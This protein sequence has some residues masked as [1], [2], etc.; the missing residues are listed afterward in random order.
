[1]LA[2]S[3]HVLAYVSLQALALDLLVPLLV[4]LAALVLLRPDPSDR[5]LLAGFVWGLVAC[6]CYD[7]FRLPTIYGAHLWTDFFGAVGGWATGTK[8]NL[9]VGYLWRYVGDGGGIAVIFYAIAASVRLAAWPKL[10]VITAAIAYA[11]CPIWAGL[12]LTDLLA[13]GGRELFALTLP[14]LALSLGGHLIYGLLLG[15]GYWKSRHLERCWPLD[16]T[17]ALRKPLA[18]LHKPRHREPRAA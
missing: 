6:A 1:V 15:I 7:A 18:R 16:A 14:T 9:L 13:P 10:V 11:L 4:V 17:P 2:I 5:V 3:A 12:V 8:S